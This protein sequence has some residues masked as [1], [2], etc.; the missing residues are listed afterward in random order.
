M[1]VLRKLWLL[2]AQ[3]ATLCLAALFVVATLRPELLGQTAEQ[4]GRVVLLQETS[5]PVTA[6]K[7]TSF[8]DAARKASPA[9]VNIFTSK[10]MRQRHPLLDDETLRRY[11][12]DLAQRLPRQR[13]TSLGSG[14]IVTPDGY[15]LTNNHVIDGADDIQL[16]LADGQRLTARVRG[17]DPESTS[18]CSRPTETTSPPSPSARSIASRSAIS[19]SRSAIRSAS[20]IP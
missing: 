4:E 16:V 18:P 2:F 20:A 14:V 13:T 5:T 6:H 12:P 10:E 9:V 19:C 3:A 11:F 7:I 8:A 17:T 15:V 1:P